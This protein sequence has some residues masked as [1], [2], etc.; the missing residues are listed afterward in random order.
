MKYKKKSSLKKPKTD[1]DNTTPNIMPNNMNQMAFGGDLK[2][3]G[4][5]L[6][7]TALSEW[8]PNII[9][10]SDYGDTS[11]GKSLGEVASIHE[12]FDSQSPIS[13]NISSKY[14]GQTGV[15]MTNRDK[16][17]YNDSLP[18]AKAGSKIGEMYTGAALGGVGGSGVS[19]QVMQTGI[20]QGL[21]AQ[22]DTTINTVPQ[23]P[24]NVINRGYNGNPVSNQQNSSPY[25]CYGG[26]MK[27]Y[28]GNLDE[29]VTRYDG[30]FKHSDKS[31]ENIHNGIPLGQSNIVENNEVR[32]NSVVGKTG[33]KS[34]V[35]DYIFSD[36]L[37]F[38]NK[39]K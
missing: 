4:L 39:K 21:N 13:K 32:G 2:N 1:P 8:A 33:K 16:E 5:F 6:A 25:A 30:G 10:Q 29:Y 9:K 27:G 18:F 14:S 37:I 38:S 19:G 11:Y 23:D 7:D 26:R 28:G 34:A 20:K 12:A 3:T 22:N 17:L 35:A 15:G 31:P 24:Q 36:K